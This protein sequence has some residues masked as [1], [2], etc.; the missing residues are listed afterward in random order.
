MFEFLKHVLNGQNQFASGGLLLMI[1]GSIGVFLRELPERFWWWLV[2][3]TTMTVT[4]KDD[5][6]S[7]QWVKE[8]FLEQKFLKRVRRVL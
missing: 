8:W 4:V 6:E 7:F 5:D 2:A 3:Q 1:L